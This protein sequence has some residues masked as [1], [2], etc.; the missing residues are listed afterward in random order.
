MKPSLFVTAEKVEGLRSVDEVRAFVETDVGQ[1]IWN[2]MLEYLHG[3]MAYPPFTPKTPLEGRD[4]KFIDMEENDHTLSFATGQRVLCDALV[5]LV[6]GETRYRDDAVAQLL[7]TLDEEVWPEWRHGVNAQKGIGVDHRVGNFILQFSIAYDWLHAF[8]SPDERQRIVEGLDRRGIQPA[9]A[10][11]EKDGFWVT[12]SNWSGTIVTGLGLF[13]MAVGDEHPRSQE[14]IDYAV[15]WMGRYMDVIGPEGE[16]NES[17]AYA[18]AMIQPVL[19]YNACRYHSRGEHDAFGQ[20][21]LDA[22]GHWY[23]YHSLPP[24]QMVEFG[25]GGKGSAPNVTMFCALAD[26]MDDGVL[27]WFYYQYRDCRGHLYYPMVLLS[28]NPHIEPVSPEGRWP[29]GRAFPGYS[30]NAISRSSWDPKAPACVVCGKASHGFEDRKEA[31][32]GGWYHLDLDAG[33]I[34]IDGYGERLIVDLG[35]SGGYGP[36]GLYRGDNYG[37]GTFGHNVLMIGGR[38]TLELGASHPR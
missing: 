36:W 6:T 32:E 12:Y 15:P 9:F 1:S 33:Q 18:G 23:A 4:P 22:F 16:S 35:S 21:R 25:D 5:H 20:T 14:L 19:F 13:G 2:P 31:G 8:L 17:A 38:N 37:K 27:Q 26:L 30:Q 28:I 24:G 3:F 11:M 29:R 34:T 7:C 10:S